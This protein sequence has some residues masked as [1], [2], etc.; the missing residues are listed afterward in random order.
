MHESHHPSI[1]QSE[2]AGSDPERERQQQLIKMFAVRKGQS[3]SSWSP[4]PPSTFI[5]PS[6]P[7]QPSINP[8]G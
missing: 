3:R 5:F 8:S 1:Q 7:P 4:T 2:I 6:L